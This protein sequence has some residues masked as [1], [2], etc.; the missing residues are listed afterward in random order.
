MKF[1]S[2]L[3]QNIL[4]G[5]F[6]ELMASKGFTYRRD[7]DIR[8]GSLRRLCFEKDNLT[9]DVALLALKSKGTEVV[10]TKYIN[11]EAVLDVK[12]AIAYMKHPSV[13]LP[14]YK[15][16]NQ[17]KVVVYQPASDQELE[18][19]DIGVQIPVP[20]K[21][22]VL[23]EPVPELL[24]GVGGSGGVYQSELNPKEVEVFYRTTL[25]RMGFREKQDMG[26]KIMNFK[27]LRF[28]SNNMAME[29]YLS[30][31]GENGS[32]FIVVKYMDK[33][34]VSKIEANPLSMAKLPENDN[35]GGADLVD[36]PRPADSSVRQSGGTEKN[37]NNLSYITSMNV[38]AVR[39]F[40]KQEMPALG[41]ELANTVNIGENDTQYAKEHKGVG[42]IRSVPLGVNLD[43]ADIIRD[44]YVLEF[45]SN[46]ATVQIMIYPNYVNPS[47]SSMVDIEYALA[48]NRGGK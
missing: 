31:R 25:K 40:Y 14:K 13:E 48:Q 47:A 18:I 42:F 2:M 36:V 10:M 3:D 11:S 15:K 30:A 22:K 23:D 41:W 7:K 21:S 32:S 27:R 44:S 6:K 24:M 46:S 35:V 8:E 5:Q 39:D 34:G 4:E 33:E 9:V 29:L 37:R 26:F 20:P 12:D 43:L 1:V 38:L 19:S 45:K 17:N 16:D 28:E